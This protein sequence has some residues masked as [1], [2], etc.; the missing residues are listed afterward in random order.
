MII[1]GEISIHSF[2]QQWIT[3]VNCQQTP[4][5]FSEHDSKLRLSLYSSLFLWLLKI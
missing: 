2:P 4:A 1:L 5:D 3:L